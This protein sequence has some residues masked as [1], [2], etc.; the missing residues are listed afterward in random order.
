MARFALAVPE[1]CGDVIRNR[2]V[3][4][5]MTQEAADAGASL[6]LFPEAT[7]TM[8]ANVD[9]PARDLPL[10]EPIPEGETL[11]MLAVEARRGRLWIGLGLFEREAESLYDSAVL[12]NAEGELVLHYRRI[13][14]GWHSRRADPR[15]YREGASLPTAF[16]PWGKAAFLI[17]GDLFD[18]ALTRRAAALDLNLLLYPFAR[19]FPSDVEVATEWEMER[20]AYAKAAASVGALSLMSNY[21]GCDETFGG[22]MVVSAEGEILAELPP[23]QSGLLL[24]DLVA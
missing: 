16:T 19:A 13:T 18:E 5:Q 21:L 10:G 6:V 8:L 23:G 3:L 9:D 22:A 14:P 2:K 15:I 17:C 4:R 20:L 24:Y 12:L 7:V 11:R 1:L